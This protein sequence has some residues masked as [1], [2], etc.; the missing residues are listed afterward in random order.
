MMKRT[1]AG[2]L[3][4]VF[5]ALM[6]GARAARVP[7][8]QGHFSV[9]PPE[10]W[11]ARATDYNIEM[12]SP[13]GKASLV[14]GY[15]RVMGADQGLNDRRRNRFKK[16]VAARSKI[17]KVDEPK[18]FGYRAYRIEF[19]GDHPQTGAG[20]RGFSLH[21]YV[22]GAAYNFLLTAPAEDYQGYRTSANRTIHT[23]QFKEPG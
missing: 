23:L 20:Y 7:S 6:V 2:L 3:L 4:V 16:A 21:L 15:L 1:L 5:G 18:L 8:G 10:G 19:Q 9:I 12:T 11:I 17:V 14:A 13:D 22:P